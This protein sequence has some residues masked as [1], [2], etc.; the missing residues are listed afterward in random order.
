[1][2]YLLE[3]RW[4]D[5]IAAAVEGILSSAPP[6]TEQTTGQ[7]PRGQGRAFVVYKSDSFDALERLAGAISSL[8]AEVRV[9]SVARAERNHQE[10]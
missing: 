2:E 10:K 9:T 4:D 1:M 5:P 3:V 6:G 8:G 7:V